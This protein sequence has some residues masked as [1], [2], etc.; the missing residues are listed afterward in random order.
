MNLSKK[1]ILYRIFF[2]IRLADVVHLATVF[3]DE[4]IEKRQEIMDDSVRKK[5][6]GR[7]PFFGER[8]SGCYILSN[9][10]TGIC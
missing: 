8:E 10:L 5:S 6:N 2:F 7:S 4:E 1:A 3:E 9:K